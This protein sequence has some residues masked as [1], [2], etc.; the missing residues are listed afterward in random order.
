MNKIITFLSVIVLI[1][2][3][4]ESANAKSKDKKVVLIT[5]TAS[6]IGKATAEHLIKQGHV[7]YGGDIQYE[8]NKYLDQIGGHSLEMDVT[9]VEQVQ[10]AV[11][12]VIKEQG[13]IDVLVNNAGYGLYGPVEEVTLDDARD[14]FEVNLFGLASV[15]QTVL[16]HMRK[17]KSGR[18]INISSMGGKIYTPLGAWYHATKH[19][20]EGWSDCLRLEVKEF[21]I[22]VVLIEPGMINTNFGNVTGT[23]IQK[24]AK[25]TAYNH[26]FEPF[27]KMAENPNSIK[28]SEPIVIA[29]LIDK[30]IAKRKPKTRYVKGKMAKSAIF[31]RNTFGDRAY[32]RMILKAFN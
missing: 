16:P 19:A 31:F 10:S 15:T 1:T 2:G 3:L 20:V 5:G 13:R 8:K 24:Y 14:Q 21:G 12:K 4:V 30:V 29:E 22:D 27:F 7:V 11:A 23:Y 18:I 25:G 26:M 9:N 6:G 32:D 28:M 17:Q